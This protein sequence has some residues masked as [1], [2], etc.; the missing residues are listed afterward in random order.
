MPSFTIGSGA[1]QFTFEVT[2]AG[3]GSLSDFTAT[4]AD[5]DVY[6][7]SIQLSPRSENKSIQCC[8]TSGCTGG[9]CGG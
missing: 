4:D 6:D 7:C 3:D 5:D 2:I 8:T 1:S 9:P